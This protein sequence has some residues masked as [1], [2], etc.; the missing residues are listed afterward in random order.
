M[1]ILF[2]EKKD[3]EDLRE[4]LSLHS[5]DLAGA[6]EDHLI[7]KENDEVVGGGKMVE[8]QKN[9]FFLE[10][11][12]VKPEKLKEGIGT[13]ILTEMIKSPWKYAKVVREDTEIRVPYRIMTTAKGPASV[14]YQ[15]HGFTRCSFSDLPETYQEQCTSCPDWEECNPVPMIIKLEVKL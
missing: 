2:A 15:K 8:F 7:V 5:M 4:I 9:H 11:L 12:G 10:V 6:I 1:E 13:I 14:F 3:E